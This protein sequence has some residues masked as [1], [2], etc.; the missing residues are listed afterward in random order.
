MGVDDLV[1]PLNLILLGG[2]HLC[3][4]A[5][6]HVEVAELGLQFGL[7]GVVLVLHGQDVLVDGDLILEEVVELVHSF[8]LQDLLVLQ[9]LQLVLQVLY[10]LLQ[11]LSEPELTF[12]Y[13]SSS[14]FWLGFERRF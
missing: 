1:Q 10:L 13:S 2:E 8:P 14:T 3:G 7:G 12:M 9:Q 11:S 4:L 5:L 6:A